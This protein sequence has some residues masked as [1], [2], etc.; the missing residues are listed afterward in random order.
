MT[1]LTQL[2]TALAKLTSTQGKTDLGALISALQQATSPS[3]AGQIT[4]AVGK[5]STDCP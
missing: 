1:Y 4:T 3:A 2:N 5:L